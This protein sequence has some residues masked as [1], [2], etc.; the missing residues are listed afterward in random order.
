ALLA[1]H[2][3]EAG[4][5]EKAI[6]YWLAAGR[7]AWGR[8]ATAEAVAV[9]HRGLALVPALPDGDW[10]REAE[11]GLQIAPGQ[12]LTANGG[13]GRPGRRRA[14][15][16]ALWGEWTDHWARADLK[17]ARGLAHEMVGLGEVSGDVLMQVMGCDAGG[18]TCLWLGEF[19]ASRAYLEKA[20]ALYDPP[21]R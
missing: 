8:S 3:E 16:F 13:R 19:T 11:L 5:P 9:L 10:R 2:C 21:H 7:Q 14:V 18:L 1:H 12:A 4:L 15:L 6:A 17:R 20:L